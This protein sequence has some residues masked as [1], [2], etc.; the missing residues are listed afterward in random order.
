[1]GAPS[2][3]EKGVLG[4]RIAREVLER[5]GLRVLS[6]NYRSAGAEVD[7]V[8]EEGEVLVFCEVKY[9]RSDQYGPPELAVTPR[10][11]ARVRRAALAYLAQKGI[12]D[13]SCRFDVLALQETGSRLEVRHWRNAF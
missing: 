5:E 6:T 8:A 9:R 1:M 10:K 2:T 13:R 3:S 11:Q 4:E 12:E 7:I